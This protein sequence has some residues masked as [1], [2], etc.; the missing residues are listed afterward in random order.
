MFLLLDELV[1]DLPGVV[2]A[3]ASILQSGSSDLSVLA[4]RTLLVLV[5][6]S[7]KNL[8]FLH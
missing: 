3:V 5:D 1:R 6:R 4:L 7:T 8:F 2:G